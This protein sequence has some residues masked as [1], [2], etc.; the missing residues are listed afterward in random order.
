MLLDFNSIARTF[1]IDPRGVFHIG[2]HHGQEMGL[3]D[4][5]SVKNVVMFEPSSLNFEVLQKNV[6]SKAL[7]VNKALGSKIESAKLRIEKSNG[8]MSNSLL[9]PALHLKQYP[10]IAFQDFENVEVITLD[11]WCSE[12]PSKAN[13]NM[14]SIDVQG[15]ELEVLVGAKFTLKNIEMISCKVNRDELYKDCAQVIEVDTFLR[16]HGFRRI[17]TRWEGVTWGEACY[18]KEDK[19]KE[20]GA[21]M[22]TVSL[23]DR[24]FSHV[25]D[26]LGFDSSCLLP[27]SRF[28]WNRTIGD[29]EELIVFVDSEIEKVDKYHSKHKVAWLI[30]PREVNPELA[31]RA[32]ALSDKFDLVVTHD[33]M[34]ISNIKNGR[35][36]PMGGS[37]ID[38][39][40]WKIY[41]KK[42]RVSIIASK[43]TYAS[44]HSLRHAAAELVPE[45]DRFGG[46]YKQ[47][48]KKNEALT[49]Y[50]FSVVIENCRQ[51]GWFTEKLIDALTMGTV[52]IYWGCPDVGEFFDARGIITFENVEDLSKILQSD[53][54]TFYDIN[55][56]V[57]E[58]N[59]KKARRFASCDDIMFNAMV[60]VN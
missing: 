47:I 60:G 5:M 56:D 18:I 58:S 3:Y 2:A 27:T 53:L 34:L 9:E 17:M 43:K 10:H 54:D 16:H 45:N 50:K 20:V 46:A 24:N 33:K 59:F 14:M 21:R 31:Y 36:S 30:E 8:G 25:K 19:I 42:K 44:G 13:C 37:W 49:E 39:D 41:E 32:I 57:I 6:G 15:F 29:N 28:D 35:F 7:L 4:S 38:P 40:D 23:V 55:K 26:E 12:N 48:A 51:P 22:P 1:N 52:P 11:S